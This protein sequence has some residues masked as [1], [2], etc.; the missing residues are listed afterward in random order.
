MPHTTEWKIRLQLT[1][2]GDSTKARAVLDTGTASVTGTGAARR[3]P[4]DENVP[5]IGDEFAA[6]RALR[7]LGS[8]LLHTAQH[9][10]EAHGS[11]PE[12]RTSP[13]SGW[14]L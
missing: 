7:D 4:G 8:R 9:D 13:T 12:P 14:S 1:E 6:G 3:A 5:E 11:A 2:D 10:V